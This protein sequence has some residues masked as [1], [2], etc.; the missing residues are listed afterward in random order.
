MT[1]ETTLIACLALLLAAV[2]HCEVVSAR[3]E[4]DRDEEK[5]F[6]TDVVEDV[7]EEKTKEVGVLAQRTGFVLRQLRSDLQQL[8]LQE[9]SAP[10]Y[11][12]WERLGKK[13]KGAFNELWPS[14]KE[15]ALK[16]A[17]KVLLEK[18]AEYLRSQSLSEEN[19]SDIVSSLAKSIRSLGI[20]ITREGVQ[21]LDDV[22]LEFVSTVAEP[23]KKE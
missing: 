13:I 16:I 19:V 23:S 1:S 17:T 22:L 8:A 21:I 5:G 6:A 9:R 15:N 7:S 12:F 4:E 2:A 20:D 14:L 10:K 18:L 11:G 3:L